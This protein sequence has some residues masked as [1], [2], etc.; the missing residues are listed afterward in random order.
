MSFKKIR[1]IFIG[2]LAIF[3]ATLPFNGWLFFFY[4]LLCT[5]GIALLVYLP[6]FLYVGSI[7]ER[8]VLKAMG[9]EYE[10]VGPF[11]I[12]PTKGP[13]TNNQKALVNNIWELKKRGATNTQIDQALSDLG[14][15]KKEVEEAF[16]FCKKAL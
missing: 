3:I 13:K 10:K 1:R 7:I 8:Q 5:V 11:R 16:E 6:V 9:K 14:W 4:S 15:T 2:A 12:L